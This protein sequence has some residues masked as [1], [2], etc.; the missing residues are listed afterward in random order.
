MSAPQALRALPTPAVLS[1]VCTHFFPARFQPGARR[2]HS[3][4]LPRIKAFFHFSTARTHLFPSSTLFSPL[5]PN[6]DLHLAPDVSPDPALER[7]CFCIAVNLLRDGG[8]AYA[9]KHPTTFPILPETRHTELYDKRYQA[10]A[11]ASASATMTAGPPPILPLGSAASARKRSHEDSPHER[12]ANRTRVSS[13][14]LAVDFSL[15]GRGYTT[16]ER[17]ACMMCRVLW[18]ATRV[19][20]RRARQHK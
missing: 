10:Q 3:C 2:F 6:C 15:G 17:P 8:H 19:G 7:I 18:R 13:R 1:E 12:R 20:R 9:R 5:S 16:A 14:E 4:A 11:S